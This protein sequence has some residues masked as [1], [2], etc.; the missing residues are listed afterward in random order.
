[1]SPESRFWIAPNWP[2]IRKITMTSQFSDMTPSTNF[3]TLFEGFETFVV[4]SLT[5][6]WVINLGVRFEAGGE[7]GGGKITPYLKKLVRMIL[8][9]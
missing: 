4:S 2:C 7:G 8:D 6:I 5:L 3:L 9:T 1:M